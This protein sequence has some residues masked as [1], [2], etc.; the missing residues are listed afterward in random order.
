MYPAALSFAHK[1][2]H[3]VRTFYSTKYFRHSQKCFVLI[4]TY[5]PHMG[6]SLQL[7]GIAL[8]GVKIVD[9]IYIYNFSVQFCLI[10]CFLG[11]R[12]IHIGL[13]IHST[14]YIL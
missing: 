6:H 10:L 11:T 9:N 14:K 13:S 7:N 8:W 4:P 1:Q 2:G 5:A 12:V 3:I